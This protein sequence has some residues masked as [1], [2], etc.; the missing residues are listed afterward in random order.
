MGG[1]RGQG[2][3]VVTDDL[4]GD[5]LDHSLLGQA[6]DVLKVEAMFQSFERFFD[7]PSLMVELAEAA[8]RVEL[9]VEQIGYQDALLSVRRDVADQAHAL[10]LARALVVE[11]VLFVRRAQHDDPFR[12]PR[13][14]ELAHAGE[15]SVGLVNAHAKL[16]GTLVQHGDQPAAG[17]AAVEQQQVSRRE[18]VE[19]LEK[20]LPFAAFAG[21]V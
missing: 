8:R 15:A 2:L 7:T 12:L 5:I 4:G 1:K 21:A 11:R 13:K 14:H 19:M 18:P 16:D 3:Q 10:R 6:G 9:L 17:I 20:E